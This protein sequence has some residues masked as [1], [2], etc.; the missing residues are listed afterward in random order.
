MYLPDLDLACG[1][2]EV[3]SCGFFDVHNTPPWD[4]WV[5]LREAEPDLGQ[6]LVCWVPPSLVAVANAGIWVNPEQCIR[7]LDDTD[8][9]AKHE[10]A[11]L[12]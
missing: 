4:C 5:A 8:L 3:E 9:G 7:W 6:Y 2:S 12:R 1:A 10:L 11:H